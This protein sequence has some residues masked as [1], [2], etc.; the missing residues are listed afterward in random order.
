MSAEFMREYDD[1]SVM[2]A[3]ENMERTLRSFNYVAEYIKVIE[4]AYQ[5]FPGGVEEIT[6]MVY[7]AQFVTDRQ[8][9]DFGDEVAAFYNGEL[10]GLEF[11][12]NIQPGVETLFKRGYA[13]SYTYH[14]LTEEQPGHISLQEDRQAMDVRFSRISK[15]IRDELQVPLTS[16]ELNPLYEAFGQSISK[17]LADND[18]QQNLA[19]LGFR[20]VV[21]EA[22]KPVGKNIAMNQAAHPTINDVELNYANSIQRTDEV[23]GEQAPFDFVEW[24]DVTHLKKMIYMNYLKA[25][26]RADLFDDTPLDESDRA[27]EKE[28]TEYNRARTR[29]EEGD[30]M[31]IQ[32]E[33]FGII[34]GEESPNVF[35]KD[36]EIRGL[37]AGLKIVEAPTNKRLPVALKEPYSG[38]THERHLEASVAIRLTNPVFTHYIGKEPTVELALDRTVDIPLSY[39]NVTVKHIDALALES[40]Q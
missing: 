23:L 16:H 1:D 24:T 5:E 39:K 10:L 35:N 7:A 9:D 13:Q 33:L 36:T 20:M 12:N 19:L 6:N 29:F 8:S 40:D 4:D 17:S 26:V 14:K 30:L 15:G 21:L 37:F 27:I 22:L 2:A 38:N 34:S 18:E 11:I 25:T 28:M 3:V 31:S 32:G